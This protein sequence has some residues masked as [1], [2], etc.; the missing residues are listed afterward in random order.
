VLGLVRGEIAEAG[1]LRCGIKEAATPVAQHD[2]AAAG[3][4]E[5]QVV[6]DLPTQAVARASTKERGTGTERQ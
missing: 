6:G 1:W 4:G 2:H 5:D 3:G